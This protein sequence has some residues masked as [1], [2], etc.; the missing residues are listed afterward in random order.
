MKTLLPQRRMAAKVLNVGENKVWF[1]PERISEIKEAITKQ[2]VEDLIKDKA[3]KRKPHLGQKRR[4]GKINLKRK[5][6]GRRRGHGHIKKI[7]NKGDYIDKIRKLRSFIKS[8]KDSKQINKEDYAK[9]YKL[10]KAGIFKNK[11]AITDYLKE[12][13]K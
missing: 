5:R 9:I 13:H 6:K 10:L 11:Q 2:D 12:K 7:I 8:L 4:A 1:D 3:I